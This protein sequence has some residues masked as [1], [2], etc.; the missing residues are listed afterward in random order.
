MIVVGKVRLVGAL[1]VRDVFPTEF[2]QPSTLQRV[3]RLNDARA[4]KVHRPKTALFVT[5]LDNVSG[6]GR[7]AIV[8]GSLRI[9]DDL[10]DRRADATGIPASS[11]TREAERAAPL[12][13]GRDA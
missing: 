10:P 7:P 11:E 6:V 2:H 8:E 1:E 3:E 4:A 12:R 13:A 5:P 9:L